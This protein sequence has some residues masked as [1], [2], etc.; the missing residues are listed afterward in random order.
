MDFGVRLRRTVDGW[1]VEAYG[2]WL[3]VGIVREEVT[4]FGILRKIIVSSRSNVAACFVLPTLDRN[5]RLWT[6][7]YREVVRG[8][9]NTSDPRVFLS[10]SPVRE[11]TG[12]RPAPNA[13][14]NGTRQQPKAAP[15]DTS[16]RRRPTTRAPPADSDPRQRPQAHPDDTA[17]IAATE[18]KRRPRREAPTGEMREFMTYVQNAF[19]DATGWTQDNSYPSL[20]STVDGRRSPRPRPSPSLSDPRRTQY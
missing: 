15:F 19:Y 3:A 6:S 2:V 5:S 7:E 4:W 13:P 20:N 11:S 9:Q 10:D 12:P 1:R 14:Q 17:I 18:R 8:C 16:S